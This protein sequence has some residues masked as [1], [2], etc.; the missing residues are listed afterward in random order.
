ML[1]EHTPEMNFGSRA[2]SDKFPR[3]NRVAPK[4]PPLTVVS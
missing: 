3:K 2:D 4:V 1:V